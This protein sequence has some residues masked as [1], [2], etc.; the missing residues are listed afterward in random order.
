MGSHCFFWSAWNTNGHSFV[1]WL[2]PLWLVLMFTKKFLK[3]QHSKRQNSQGRFLAIWTD[4]KIRY[5]N[6][7]SDTNTSGSSA[8]AVAQQVVWG[9]GQK[10]RCS[11]NSDLQFLAPTHFFS[12]QAR[13]TPKQTS[14]SLFASSWEPQQQAPSLPPPNYLPTL[15]LCTFIMPD[16][17]TR[18]FLSSP[19][20]LSAFRESSLYGYT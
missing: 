14:S 16:G 9:L 20:C 2:T 17:L 15:S 18:A 3:H 10:S 13:C 8:R 4:A 1:T 12:V 6:S 11:V 7:T 19:G 5:F